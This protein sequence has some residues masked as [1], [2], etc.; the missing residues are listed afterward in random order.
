MFIIDEMT[1]GD[2]FG[3]DDHEFSLISIDHH[4]HLGEADMKILKLLV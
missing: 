4:T 2:L 1:M 3:F